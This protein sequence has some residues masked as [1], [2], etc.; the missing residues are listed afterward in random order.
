MTLSPLTRR[1]LAVFR[2]NRRGFW[3]MWIF[4]VLFVLSLFAEFIANDRPLLIRYDGQFLVPVL[5][6]Y[7]GVRFGPDFLPFEA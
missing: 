5:Q 6:Y 1:R 3:S 2:A 4:L 7:S